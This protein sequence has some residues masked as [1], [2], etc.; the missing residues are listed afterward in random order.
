MLT[1]LGRS[2]IVLS[3]LREIMQIKDLNHVEYL[4]RYA[5][6]KKDREI[7]KDI[8][9]TVASWLME[10]KDADFSLKIVRLVRNAV[11]QGLTELEWWPKLDDPIIIKDHLNKITHKDFGKML[12]D[13]LII[14]EKHPKSKIL[15]A[16]DP[17][18]LVSYIICDEKYDK[19]F[20]QFYINIC[21]LRKGKYKWVF[22]CAENRVIRDINELRNIIKNKREEVG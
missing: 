22:D 1:G 8:D 7:C 14:M 20:K 6:W 16:D 4:V 9:S 2:V 21:N 11:F 5:I 18:F 19:M 10:M 12:K 3:V 13:M 17:P 15:P